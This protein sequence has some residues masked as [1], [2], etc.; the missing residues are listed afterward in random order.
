MI[1]L[2]SRKDHISKIEA[3]QRFYDKRWGF[4]N[5]LELQVC[6]LLVSLSVRYSIFD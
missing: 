4:L 5:D 1:E 2:F 6:R 3:A